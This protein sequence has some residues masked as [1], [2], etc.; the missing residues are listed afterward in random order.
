MPNPIGQAKSTAVIYIGKKRYEIL[1][2]HAR[3]I[4][5]VAEVNIRPSAF[6]QYMIDKLSNE[7]H[8]E[9]LKELMSKEDK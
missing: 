8:N 6:L 2:K 7:A 5:Y 3:D 1:A 9:M 4:S